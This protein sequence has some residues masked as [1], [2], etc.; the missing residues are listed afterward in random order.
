MNLKEVTMKMMICINDRNIQGANECLEELIQDKKKGGTSFSCLI[1]F[2][3]D[4]LVWLLSEPEFV[5]RLTE[6]VVT[7]SSIISWGDLANG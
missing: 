6:V 5:K 7:T 3:N 4:D 1:V 2:R